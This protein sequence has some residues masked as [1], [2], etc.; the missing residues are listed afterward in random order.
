MK[1]KE[2]YC[3]RCKGL[4]ILDYIISDYS[5]PMPILVC[6]NCG[7]VEDNVILRNK[8]KKMVLSIDK[9]KYK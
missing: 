7:Y 6:K 3:I 2:M 4:M 1:T 8:N 9:G 5:C